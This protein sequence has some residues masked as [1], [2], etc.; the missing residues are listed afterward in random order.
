MTVTSLGG[1]T[2]EAHAV[3]VA[4]G[5]SANYL[6]LESEEQYKN[7]GT[8]QLVYSRGQFD[9]KATCYF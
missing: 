6:G 3:I 8:V 1:E 7:N 4:T 5:A 2:V 9:C